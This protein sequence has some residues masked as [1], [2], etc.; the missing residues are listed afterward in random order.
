MMTDGM[1]MDLVVLTGM[2]GAGKTTA[3]RVFQD[4]GFY[5]MDNL[6]PALL[7]AVVDL[8][9]T[10]P[11]AHPELRRVAVVCDVRS[12]DV[13]DHLQAA[14]KKLE[15]FPEVKPMLVFLDSLT[16]VLV[17][18]YSESRRPHPMNLEATLEQNIEEERKLLASLS[19]V[20][21]VRID[22]SQ[23]TL[24]EFQEK[25]M[26][27]F[28]RGRRPTMMVLVTSFGY[29]HGLPASADL[30]F[31]VRFLPNPFY[32]KSLSG[33]T[34]F[35][36]GV[37]AFVMKAPPCGQYLDK[38]RDMLDFLVPHFLNEG[39]SHLSI[40]VGCTGGKHRSVVLAEKLTA[41][42]KSRLDSS[43]VTVAVHHRDIGK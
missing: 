3:L 4:I 22:T 42:L 26:S 6:P 23:L 13:S 31:D 37:E 41:H 8:A 33:L 11:D 14:F 24:R 21:D 2:S 1:Q 43:R 9:L 16:P 20:A 32:E 40:A 18:R 5:V 34:G 27:F 7:P 15:R 25:L 35:D 17:R 29:K 10:A 38:I 30:V 39:K 19:A 36:P 12:R 28:S